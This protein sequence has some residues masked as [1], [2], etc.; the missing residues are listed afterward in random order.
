MCLLLGMLIHGQEPGTMYHS[1]KFWYIVPKTYSPREKHSHLRKMGVMSW[2]W[3]RVPRLQTK[4]SRVLVITKTCNW[5]QNKQNEISLLSR[6]QK[7][8][9]NYSRWCC[10][11]IFARDACH[12]MCFARIS[13]W[14]WSD[15]QPAN[16]RLYLS[17]RLT[18]S[19]KLSRTK[20]CC[21][22]QYR[23]DREVFLLMFL[24]QMNAILCVLPPF[25][26]ISRRCASGTK[27]RFFAIF[28]EYSVNSADKPGPLALWWYSLCPSKKIRQH[29]ATTWKLL[30]LY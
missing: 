29:R 28:V 9:R 2:F 25:N 21:W 17:Q 30:Y 13:D 23:A 1:S 18:A 15:S 22:L 7:G 10:Q 20:L 27:W 3:F 6:I 16:L 5:Y 12:M 19:T 24:E 11:N 4:I 8:L 14:E 26:K